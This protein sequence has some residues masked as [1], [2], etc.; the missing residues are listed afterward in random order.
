M[1]D[2]VPMHAEADILIVDDKIEQQPLGR[3]KGGDDP[4]GKAVGID[5]DA[6]GGKAGRQTGQVGGKGAFQQ[7]HLVMVAD[8]AQ[9]GLGCHR[10]RAP[11]DE[12]GSRSLLQ[13]LDPLADRRRGDMQ[14]RR[15]KV[16][17]SAPMDGGKGGKLGGIKH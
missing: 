1:T 12:K 17:R 4:G 10:R 8:Q 5:R 13:R 3:G 16:E 9:A 11:A 14:F 15:R 7:G 2:R 6:Q